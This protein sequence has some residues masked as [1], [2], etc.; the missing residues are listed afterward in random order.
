MDLLGA[1]G[2]ERLLYCLLITGAFANLFYP[3]VRVTLYENIL[4]SKRG[5]HFP[6]TFT[7]LEPYFQSMNNTLLGNVKL[8]E[9][10]KGNQKDLQPYLSL[11]DVAVEKFKTLFEIHESVTSL[12]EHLPRRDFVPYSRGLRYGLDLAESEAVLKILTENLANYTSKLKTHIED[13]E[14]VDQIKKSE[15]YTSYI[16][17]LNNLDDKLNSYVMRYD[18]WAS[19][20]IGATRSHHLSSSLIEK[21]VRQNRHTDRTQMVNDYRIEF[22]GFSMNASEIGCEVIRTS[23]AGVKHF[24]KIRVFC[25]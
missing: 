11:I 17:V 12:G 25:F 4:E 23:K 2:A 21:F 15:E 14:T 13:N 19:N 9:I 10:L 7:K 8:C 6:L 20:V 5:L 3:D 22:C 16:V 24:C 1:M 18:D